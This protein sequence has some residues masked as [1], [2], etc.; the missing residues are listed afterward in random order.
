MLADYACR[1]PLAN[2]SAN[3]GGNWI[4]LTRTSNNQWAYYNSAGPWEN[5]FPMGLRLTSV[6]GETIEDSMASNEGGQGQAQ[7]SDVS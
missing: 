2:V 7:F 5:N 4:G 3:I 1:V 6:T